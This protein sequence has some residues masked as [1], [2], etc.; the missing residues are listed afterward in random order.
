MELVVFYG[1]RCLAANLLRLGLK[2]AAVFMGI[3]NPNSLQVGIND[4]CTHKFHAPFLEIPGYQIGKGRACFAGFEDDFAV[5][6]MPQI[7]V[8]ARPFLLNGEKHLGIDDGGGNFAAISNNSWIL[9]QL[10]YL[11][12]RIVCDDL[13]IKFIE[14]TSKS[15]SLMENTHPG[16]AGLE[17]L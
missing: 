15:L 3:D 17:A 9:Q 6:K 10:F 13:R 16:E 12:G 1:D 5:C 14:C 8:K 11:A 2:V 4:D 7:P